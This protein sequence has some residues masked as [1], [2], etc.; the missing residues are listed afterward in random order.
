MTTTTKRC[1]PKDEIEGSNRVSDAFLIFG[2]AT[3]HRGAAFIFASGS[4]NLER[5]QIRSGQF[6]RFS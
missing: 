5:A 1:L 2:E 4:D 6:A 3:Y